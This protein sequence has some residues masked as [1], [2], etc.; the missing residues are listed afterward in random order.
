MSPAKADGSRD[1]KNMIGIGSHYEKF[2]RSNATKRDILSVSGFFCV[3]KMRQEYYNYKVQKVDMEIR[4]LH[5]EYLK[6]LK[7]VFRYDEQFIKKIGKIFYAIDDGDVINYGDQMD[8]F[9]RHPE[10]AS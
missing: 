10:I 4:D 9:G 7:S 8:F 2:L 1:K 3:S 6:V 5:T